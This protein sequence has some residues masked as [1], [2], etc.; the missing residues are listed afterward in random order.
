METEQVWGVEQENG[1]VAVYVA[2]PGDKAC[3]PVA[4]SP[5]TAAALGN[6]LIR[7]AQSAAAVAPAAMPEFIQRRWDED[8]K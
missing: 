1:R 7:A 8:A 4:L 3:P 5:D 2:R 6:A